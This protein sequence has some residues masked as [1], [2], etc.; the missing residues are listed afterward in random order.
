MSMRAVRIMFQVHL[1]ESCDS[2]TI[3]NANKIRFFLFFL[4][5]TLSLHLSRRKG[6]IDIKFHEKYCLSNCEAMIV[7]LARVR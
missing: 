1:N 2:W 7:T 4:S 3:Q 5:F 6:Q